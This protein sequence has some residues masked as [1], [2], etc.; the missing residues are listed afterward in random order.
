MSIARKC[1]PILVIICAGTLLWWAV[2]GRG[3]RYEGHPVSYWLTRLGSANWGKQ[4]EARRAFRNMGATAVPSLIAELQREES[5][6]QRK[7][8]TY[9]RRVPLLK[10]FVAPTII[11]TGAPEGPAICTLQFHFLHQHAARA[12]GEIGP[13]ASNA[14]P[15]LQANAGQISPPIVRAALMKIRN[16]PH[17]PLTFTSTNLNASLWWLDVSVA[18]EFHEESQAL[19]PHL[20]RA[21]W[22]SNLNQVEIAAEALG[23]I[24]S[25]PE[26][27]VPALMNAVYRL[28]GKPG[29]ND[30]GLTFCYWALSQFQREATPAV[31]DLRQCLTNSGSMG[32]IR[33]FALRSL[34]QILPP[35]EA[36]KLLTQTLKGPDPYLKLNAKSLLDDMNN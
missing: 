21:L 12:L 15:L 20:C 22:S 31:P 29:V 36:R 19:V 9:A 3:P 32:G 16:E 4:V 24:H 28:E 26:I 2:R 18:A 1:I 35:E 27:V 14:I 11:E 30:G 6:F 10:R 34:S 17:T 25:N 33:C 5:P 13:A 8:K 7:F 23:R